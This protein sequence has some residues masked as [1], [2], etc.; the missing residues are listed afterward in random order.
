MSC[1]AHDL[2]ASRKMLAAEDVDLI[3]EVVAKLPSG[4]TVV[5]V[6]AGS[7]TTALSVFAERRDVRL[8]SIEAD[9]DTMNWARQAVDNIGCSRGWDDR[10]EDALNAATSF[11]DAHAGFIILDAAHTE[12]DVEAELRAW[13]PKLVPGGYLLVHDYDAKDAPNHYPGVKKAVDPFIA[14]GEL[15][16]LKQQ[17]WSLLARSAY[18]LPLE[19]REPDPK[20]K[21]GRRKKTLI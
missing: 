12:S 10:V 9:V 19:S 3:R 8:V 17:G 6:G 7:G 18:G 2:A 15:R 13:L 20:P 21:R 14:R 11:A 1:P 16:W 5:D 4:A